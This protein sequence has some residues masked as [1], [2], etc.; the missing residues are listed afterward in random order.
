MFAFAK[1]ILGAV[2][3]VTLVAACSGSGGTVA[4]TAK[5][6]AATAASQ[7][8]TL[9]PG[10][11]EE[12]AQA[13]SLPTVA[14]AELTG[15]HSP[16]GVV[17]TADGKWAFASETGSLA[18]LSTTGF[19]PKLVRTI[20]LAG[21]PEGLAITPNGQDVLVAGESG[22][23]VVSVARAQMRRGNPVLGTLSSSGT[24]AIQVA[25]SPDSRFA[26]ITLE[27][28][29]KAAVYNLAEA[30][31]GGFGPKDFVGDIPLEEGPS[32]MA[33]SPDGKWLYATSEQI[34]GAQQGILSVINL[35]EA[36]TDPAK[37]VVTTADPGCGPVRVITSANGDDVWVTARESDA[38]VL[39]SAAKLVSDPARALVAWVRVGEAPVDLALID[40]GT[41]IIV[42]NSNRS[43]V[44]GQQADLGVVDVADVLTSRPAAA[45]AGQAAEVGLIGSGMFP[46]ELALEANGKTMLVANYDSN[47]VESVQVAGIPSS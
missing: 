18:V 20:K 13:P 46:R 30:L 17:T 23:T 31:A 33:V 12:V 36:E 27:Y 29:A 43:Q 8:T 2:A 42:G 5:R 25:F 6:S 21:Q 40:G 47:E 14:T 32:G 7:A 44:R 3:V 16:F 35:A 15:Q 41:R 11:S 38:L 22:A 1:P 39:F 9:P 37:S 26:F 10:C 4:T 19:E 34:S 28:S 45:G 24:G